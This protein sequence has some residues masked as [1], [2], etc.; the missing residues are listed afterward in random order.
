MHIQKLID[1]PELLLSSKGDY[2]AAAF[3]GKPWEQPKV[4]DAMLKLVPELPHLKKILVSF[5]AGALKTWMCFCCK[6]K[7]D[8]A[9]ARTSNAELNAAWILLTNDHNKGALSFY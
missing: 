1:N 7:K 8:R 5:P 3:D 9:I 2:H 4:V 6:F